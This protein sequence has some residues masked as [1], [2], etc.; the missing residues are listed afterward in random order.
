MKLSIIIPVYQV[1]KYVKK[2]VSSLLIP[3]RND[4]ELIIINDGTK[5]RS[6]EIVEQSFSDSR[7]R[8]IHQKNA[9]LS[10]ARNRGIRAA[11]GLYFWFSILMIGPRL[12]V[13]LRFWI[14]LTVRLMYF[15]LS[16]IFVIMKITEGRKRLMI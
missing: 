9:G 1:E 6:I 16:R 12:I 11:K 13:Y 5:D 10:A 4:Y 3:N 8:I 15:V 14:F 7:I 2:C